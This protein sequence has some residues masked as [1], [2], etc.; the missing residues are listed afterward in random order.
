MQQTA[1]PAPN[2]KHVTET[3]I[4]D[5]YNRIAEYAAARDLTGLA[6]ITQEFPLPASELDDLKKS[7]GMAFLL[8]N[9]VNLVNAIE[10]YGESWLES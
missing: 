5:M 9:N 10:K 4:T 2:I 6:K 3:E 7:E 8:E 1:L